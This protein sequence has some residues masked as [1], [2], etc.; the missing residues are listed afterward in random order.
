MKQGESYVDAFAPVPLSTAGRVMMS[1]AAVLDLEMHCL[2]LSQAFIQAL[3]ADLPEEVPQV[4]IR[5]Q[6]G[7]DEDPGVVY[8][9]C[10]PLYGHPASARCLHYTLDRFMRESG[11]EKTRFEETRG[12]WIRPAGGT[13][14]HNIYM[15]AH[16][17]DTLML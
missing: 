6:S 8:E 5:P 15:S 7:W 4:F 14:A 9:V 1:L 13:Y 12:V 10:A 2:D 3:W 11:F 16:I 17:D